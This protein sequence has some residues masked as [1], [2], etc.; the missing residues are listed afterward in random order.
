LEDL[1]IVGKGS[2]MFRAGKNR[3]GIGFIVITERKFSHLL[4]TF[5]PTFQ[6]KSQHLCLCSTSKTVTTTLCL[7]QQTPVCTHIMCSTHW[8]TTTADCSV[9][10]YDLLF[11]QRHTS[12]FNCRRCVRSEVVRVSL[13]VKFLNF[14][15]LLRS[16]ILSL[17][18]QCGSPQ[19]LLGRI[20]FV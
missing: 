16:F 11:V 14:R 6:F 13:Y 2:V 19:I 5:K 7:L 18:L 15:K 3:F 17:V 9:L 12:Y 8:I 20:Y 1:C 4:C 10:R